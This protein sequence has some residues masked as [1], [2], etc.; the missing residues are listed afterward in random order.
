MDFK[1]NAPIFA[2]DAREV[3]HLDRVVVNPVT[4][5]LSHLVVRQG[6][7]FG[8]HKLVP[9]GF[10]DQA[11]EDQITLRPAAGDLRTLPPFEEPHEVLM[12]AGPARSSMT[13]RADLA[14]GLAGMLDDYGASAGQRLVAR[15]EPNIPEGA[16]AVKTGARVVTADGKHGGALECI[17]IAPNTRRVTH[18]QIAKGLLVREARLIPTAWVVILGEDEV[19]LSVDQQTL[20]AVGPHPN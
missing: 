20:E 1:H 17:A 15:S 11:T 5:E 7:L 10:V 8:E 4:Q 3:G 18:L 6:L 12:E 13:L 16:V 19:H 2:A 14:P 9:I